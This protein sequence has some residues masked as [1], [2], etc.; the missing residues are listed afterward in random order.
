VLAVALATVLTVIDGSIVNVALPTIA[1]DVGVG[2]AE[3]IWAV[4]AYQIAVFVCL[5][6]LASLAEALGYRRVF[7]SGIAIFTLASLSCAMATSLQSLIVGRVAQ[8]LGAACIMCLNGAITRFNY[9]RAILTRGI[10]LN[11]MVVAAGAALGPTL[12]SA[13]LAVGP[14]P[15]L[16]AVNV[17]LGFIAWVIAAKSMP[18]PPPHG[19]GFDIPAALLNALAFGMIMVGADSLSHDDRAS[20][21]VLELAVGI[22]AGFAL[23]KRSLSQTRPLVPVDLLRIPIFALSVCSSVTA[24]TAHTLAFVAMPFVLQYGLGRSEVETGLLMTPWP[25]AVIIAAPIA[26]RLAERY[27]AGLLGALGLAVMT[28]GLFLLA[29]L[30]AA[31]GPF[32]IAW[33]MAVCG[34]GFGIFQ[35]PNNRILLTSAPMERS[36]AAAGMLATGRLMGQVIGALLVAVLFRLFPDSQGATLPLGVACGFA[37]VACLLSGARMATPKPP[38]AGGGPDAETA[39]I[40]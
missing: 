8:G 3:I 31:P 1:R 21:G 13:I 39:D 2:P 14:W 34:A 10:A 12:G 7:L 17:P 6:P 25:A 16:F 32:D 18:S 5:L 36:G 35:S 24:F 30:P 38:H 29:T 26:G 19:Q 22:A 9:P 40:A 27:H 37:A 23:V 20:L 4:N 15:W 11:A 33:R 28:A